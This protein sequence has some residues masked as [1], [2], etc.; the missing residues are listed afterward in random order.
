MP[1]TVAEFVVR[2]KTYDQS[3][4][5][6]AKPHF[7][8]LCDLLGQPH[9]AAADSAGENYAFEKHVRKTSGAE[10]FAD[11]WFRD[12]FAWEYKKKRKNLE[13][14]YTQLNDYREELGNPPLLVVCDFERFEVHT[15]YTRTNKRVYKFNLD[16]LNRNLPTAGCPLPPLDVL[17]ALFGDTDVLRPERTDAQVTQEVAK[18]FAKLAERLEIEGRSASRE[19]VAHFLM[20]LLFCLFADS[21]G[22]LPDHLFRRTIENNRLSPSKFQRMLSDLFGAMSDKEKGIFGPYAIKHFN[23]DLFNSSAVMQLDHGDLGIL[24]DVSKNYD[25]SRV[26]P[27]IFGTLFE[28]SLDPKRRSLI[29]AHY[30][31][32]QDIETLID[33]V[34]VRP[35]RQRWEEYKTRILE[36]REVERA[37]EV[38][39]DSKQARLRVDRESEKLLGQW[40]DELTAVRVLDPAC[41]SGNFL[42]VA[43]RRMLDLWLEATKLATEEGIS[44]VV[45]KM[46]S[47][48]Q[49]YGIE[50]EFYAHELASVVVWI[51]FLQWKHEHGVHEDREPVL[52]KLHNIEYG[53]AILRR[54]A[55]GKPCEP[56]WPQVDFII[57]NPPFLGGSKMR[58]ELSNEYVDSLQQMYAGRVSAGADLVT[59]WFEKARAEIS[60]AQKL[61]AGLLATQSIRGGVN[62]QVLDSIKA[63]G[64]IFMAWD[65]MPWRLEGAIVH[66][67]IIGFD[68]GH[69]MEKTLNGERVEAINSDLSSGHDLTSAQSLDENRNLCFR[70]NE[71]G[72]PFDVDPE[73]AAKMLKAPLNVNGR[74]NLDVL[75]RF[76]GAADITGRSRDMWIIDFYGLTEAQ[77]AKYEIPFETL[78]HRIEAEIE[79]T[80]NSSKPLK[81]R[82]RWW[83]HRRPGSDMREATSDLPRYIVTIRHGKHRPFVWLDHSV[84][85]DSGMYA[86]AREDDYFFGILQSAA[87]EIWARRTGTQVREAESGFRYTPTSCFD[88]FPFPWPP[89][90]EPSEAEDPH[91]K[92]IADAA[93]ELVRLRDA[94]LNPPD[95]DPAELKNRTL[96]NLYNQRP[97]WL[98]NAHEAL[99]RAVFAAYG[100]PYPLTRDEILARLLKLNH[101]R[102]A[103]HPPAS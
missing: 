70:T 41:G 76:V 23:G 51:G 77:A 61:R 64:D 94:W 33:P 12:H 68:A 99:D 74:S 20:R 48:R 86:F 31:S 67:S 6:G 25:W 89:G 60:A 88:T 39:R 26:A 95:I 19:Q 9:P 47:P 83:L 96:T 14:A 72:G 52:E 73:T 34:L 84:V 8:D 30:T 75:R 79:A 90:K 98:A 65:D 10:G 54:D 81:R 29:G 63:S 36:A 53:D 50:I 102:S 62:R 80:K 58:H 97:A 44:L 45:P 78:K 4:E 87:H 5:A 32:E 55:E 11:V 17:R 3:E 1:L 103:A 15:N 82:D 66:V 24:Y 100:W 69:E 43:L 35:L 21:I 38:A 37:E 7:L 13:K 16:D 18:K 93:R 71:R 46:V 28:R 59:Y 27:A 101:E 22:L 40:I 57:G 42:Y 56:Q 92:A 2:W 49:L 85:P 91:V